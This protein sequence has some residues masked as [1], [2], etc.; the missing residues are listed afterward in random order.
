MVVAQFEKLGRRLLCLAVTGLIV[1]LFALLIVATLLRSDP[2][3]R[4][5]FHIANAELVFSRIINERYPV[6]ADIGCIPFR[7]RAVGLF[8]GKRSQERRVMHFLGCLIVPQVVSIEDTSSNPD[9]NRIAGI[10]NLHSRKTFV[11]SIAVCVVKG[12][13]ARHDFPMAAEY[14]G[15][16]REPLVIAGSTSSLVFPIRVWTQIQPQLGVN[17]VERSYPLSAVMHVVS[18]RKTGMRGIGS[19]NSFDFDSGHA[20]PGTLGQFQSSGGSVRSTFGGLGGFLVGAIHQEG[21][22]GINDQNAER[23]TLNPKSFVFE[24]VTIFSEP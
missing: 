14:L 1:L 7:A 11:Y 18:E 12:I 22:Q 10:F 4:T 17:S 15:L 3:Y 8:V 16:F 6:F 23:D 24:A 13:W 5:N 20:Q 2:I 19:I 9:G 21:D